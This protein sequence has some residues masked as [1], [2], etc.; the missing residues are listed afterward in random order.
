[1][2]KSK[3]SNPTPLKHQTQNVNPDTPQT[4]FGIQHTPQT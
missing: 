2:N 3:K 1:M 4:Q